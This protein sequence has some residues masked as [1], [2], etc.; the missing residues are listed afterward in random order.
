[1]MMPYIQYDLQNV[2]ESRV[3][4]DEEIKWIAYQMLYGIA[5]VH[6]RKLMHRDLT[7]KNILISDAFDTYIA[8]FGLARAHQTCT[9][10]I[11]LDVVTL[12]YR[13]PELLLQHKKYDTRVDMWSIGCMVAE[14]Y[15][16]RRLFVP[17]RRDIPCQL[18]KLITVLG[19]PDI[20]FV[21]QHASPSA[22]TFFENIL[23]KFD[24]AAK[25]QQNAYDPPIA[26]QLKAAGASD[27]AIELVT[28]LLQFDFRKRLSAAQS[29]QLKWFTADPEYNTLAGVASPLVSS[30][31]D[32]KTTA[33][34][35][36]EAAAVSKKTDS[37]ESTTLTQA[38]P[39][40]PLDDGA[41]ERRENGDIEEANPSLRVLQSA[42]IEGLRSY[43]ENKAE[44]IPNMVNAEYS[45]APDV[46]ETL[47]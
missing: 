11:T 40:T 36:S 31:F 39:A 4:K 12:E 17:Q 24:A 10:D 27:G 44:K 33:D 32:H 28:S 3:L 7:L 1:M 30:H 42:D 22:A 21:R 47:Q 5:Q 37:L 45:A 15:L 18:I 38:D 46:S 6:A 41:V 34:G 14:L 16:R 29:L 8:D 13:A 2:V 35:N 25:Q 26:D 43:M 9:E 20:E 23:A 19:R